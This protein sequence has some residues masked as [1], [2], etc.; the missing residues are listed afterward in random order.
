MEVDYVTVVEN[1]LQTC[2]VRRISFSTFGQNWPTLERGLS[3][4]AELLVLP[5]D[6]NVDNKDDELACVK[7]K[8]TEFNLQWLAK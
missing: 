6:E 8:D 7:V 2:N 4:I 1:R 3:A 5:D